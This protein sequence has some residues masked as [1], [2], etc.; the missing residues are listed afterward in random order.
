MKKH[1][2]TYQCIHNVFYPQIAQSTLRRFC[3]NTF[4]SRK[5]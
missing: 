5:K 4:K 3:N 2:S 1:L